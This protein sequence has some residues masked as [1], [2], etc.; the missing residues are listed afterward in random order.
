MGVI[1]ESLD[2]SRSMFILW[3]EEH[4]LGSMSEYTACAKPS[5]FYIYVTKMAD[6]LT[7]NAH[8]KQ[9]DSNPVTACL[10]LLG[11]TLPQILR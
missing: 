3:S 2:I 11:Y 8:R 4:W 5:L 10:L 7:N 1:F 9:D 6:A